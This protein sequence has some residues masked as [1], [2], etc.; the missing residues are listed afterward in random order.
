MLAVA[1]NRKH[2]FEFISLTDAH[3]YKYYTAY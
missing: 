2:Y 3:L 1:Y